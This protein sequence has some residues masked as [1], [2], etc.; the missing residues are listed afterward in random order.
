MALS[1]AGLST[2]WSPSC[3]SRQR[4]LI[5]GGEAG[6]PSAALWHPRRSQT[7]LHGDGAA[8]ARLFHGRERTR[9]Q[10]ARS[11]GRLKARGGLRGHG[12]QQP[13][14]GRT[15]LRRGMPSRIPRDAHPGCREVPRPARPPHVR[16]GDDVGLE[17]LREGVGQELLLAG[18]RIDHQRRDQHHRRPRTTT[19]TWWSAPA[20]ARPGWSRH[21]ADAGNARRDRWSRGPHPCG[22]R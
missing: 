15:T 4:V 16:R 3:V 21:T 8:A 7:M 12:H 22:R 14:A 1:P 13:Q 5:R 2:I 19:T 10:D 9:Q 17:L 6:S 11:Q 20:P 18:R